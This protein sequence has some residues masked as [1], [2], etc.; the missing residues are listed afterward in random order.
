[1]PPGEHDGDIGG[2]EQGEE[3]ADTDSATDLLLRGMPPAS[4]DDCPALLVWGMQPSSDT[5]FALLFLRS[6]SLSCHRMPYR[7]TPLAKT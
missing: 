2:S 6:S 1:M 5:P 7:C 3:A 4:G